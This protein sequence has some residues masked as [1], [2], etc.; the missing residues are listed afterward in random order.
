[1]PGAAPLLRRELDLLGI[2]SAPS[3][4]ESRDYIDLS[5][6][7][8]NQTSFDKACKIVLN[9]RMMQRV[10]V[11]VRDPF[12]V[13]WERQLREELSKTHWGAFYR[14]SSFPSHV[15]T[16]VYG[17]R[18]GNR[19]YI[20]NL[21]TE[22]F[23]SSQ[24]GTDGAQLKLAALADPAEQGNGPPLQISVNNDL[25][26]L[27]V[28]IGGDNLNQLQ[29]QHFGEKSRLSISG[30]M[31]T[32]VATRVLD[33]LRPGL[34][35]KV[36]VWDP[37]VGSGSICISL[38]SVL[39]GTPAGSPNNNYPLKK[40]PSFD[41]GI[42]DHMV[43][44]LS[45]QSHDLLNHVSSIIGSDSS[46]DAIVTAQKSWD[47]FGLRVPMLAHGQSPIMVP[48]KLERV[49]DAFT[50]PSGTR[51]LVIVTSLPGGGEYIKRIL[52]F[53]TMIESLVSQ[54]RL[55]GAFVVT[56]KSHSFSKLSGQRRWLTDFRFKDE[57]RR[58]VELLRLVL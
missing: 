38:V 41:A 15:S 17:S 54:G 9:C 19:K 35:E 26:D 7:E 55:A 10:S 42:F 40:L 30:L 5:Q 58:D 31:G 52:H 28:D 56:N 18:L 20:Q 48:L 50:A 45:I 34:T 44:R 13:K 22:S 46:M 37:F 29:F 16:R 57:N 25:M 47:D 3:S 8:S 32:V 23:N 36:D 12:Q 6:M 33:N 51:K 49:Y 39:S 1:M 53:H 43:S 24:E 21:V 2:R 27:H 14:K 4:A 11:R